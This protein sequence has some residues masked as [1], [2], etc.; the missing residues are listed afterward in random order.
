M[1]NDFLG[2]SL[3][4]GII[5]AIIKAV[6]LVS[7]TQNAQKYNQAK[8]KVFNKLL[9]YAIEHI[10]KQILITNGECIFGLAHIKKNCE[11]GIS[12]HHIYQYSTTTNLALDDLVKEFTVNGI[13]FKG[14][15]QFT[16]NFR[17]FINDQR[18]WEQTYINYRE[19]LKKADSGQFFLEGC[20]L[21]VQIRCYDLTIIIDTNPSFWDFFTIDLSFID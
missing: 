4:Y 19:K 17:V 12:H 21:I 8:S 6:M 14:R 15:V 13:I 18:C 1:K 3:Y 7:A 11:D 2:L 10:K 5:E 9:K 20:V 16:P